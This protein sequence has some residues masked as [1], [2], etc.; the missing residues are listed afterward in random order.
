[1]ILFGGRGDWN[2][3][4]KLIMSSYIIAKNEEQVVH[5]ARKMSEKMS[6]DW[7]RK[8]WQKNSLW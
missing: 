5:L 3:V 2:V 8:L 6:E 1:M 7:E 4:D